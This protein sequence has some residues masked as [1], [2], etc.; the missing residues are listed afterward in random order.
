MHA[1]LER[2][3]SNCLF[4]TVEQLYNIYTGVAAL[5]RCTEGGHGTHA[6][7]LYNFVLLMEFQLDCTCELR[8]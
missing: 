7:H 3:C 4:S 5:Y 8:D 6:G 1:W 2:T